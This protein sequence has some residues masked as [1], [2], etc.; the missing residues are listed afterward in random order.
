MC[1]VSTGPREIRVSVPATLENIDKA[2]ERL[3]AFLTE[4]GAPIDLFAI[5]I[6]FHEAMMNAVIHGSGQDA[7]MTVHIRAELGEEGLTL[8][9]RDEGEGFPWR[10][11][12]GDIDKA[13]DSGRGLPLMR[14]YASRAEYNDAGNEVTLFR[15]YAHGAE[16]QLAAAGGVA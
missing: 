2:D 13:L 1:L 9:V 7:H 11:V 4:A 14:I 3:C 16:G 10:E 6:V 12:H 15:S 8:T 5:R